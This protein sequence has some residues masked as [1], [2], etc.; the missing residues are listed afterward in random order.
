MELPETWEGFTTCVGFCVSLG[1][2]FFSA[3]IKEV[4]KTILPH[5]TA[6]AGPDV[7]PRVLPQSCTGFH[8]R[9]VNS[10]DTGHVPIKLATCQVK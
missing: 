5:L 1:H 3:G 7:H 8:S 6:L 4:D 2:T 10:S 9:Y